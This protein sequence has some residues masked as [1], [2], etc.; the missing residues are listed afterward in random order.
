MPPRTC[1]GKGARPPQARIADNPAAYASLSPEH[2]DLVSKGLITKGMPQ[3]GVLLALGTP[4][5]ETSG[6]RDGT[7]YTRWDY[8]RLRPVYGGSFFGSYYHGCGYHHGYG[9]GYAPTV[10]YVPE[11]E[12][13]IWFRRGRVDAW[14]RVRSPYGY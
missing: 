12:A 8:T 4:D 14:D 1:E 11:R 9:L 2:Q 5:R 10:H 6:Y 13:S 3:T 7:S